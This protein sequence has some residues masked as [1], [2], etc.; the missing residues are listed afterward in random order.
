MHKLSSLQAIENISIS[1]HLIS[2]RILT[3]MQ[4]LHLFSNPT[5]S[6]NHF[7]ALILLVQVHQ[8]HIQIGK[9]AY[10]PNQ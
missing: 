2:T 4:L 3:P 6:S 1:L 5:L 10:V 9:Q 8:F 7:F